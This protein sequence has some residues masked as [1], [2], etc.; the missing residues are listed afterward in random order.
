[1]SASR[2]KKN[3]LGN[4]TGMDSPKTAREIQ[5]RKEE[6]R[7]NLLYGTIAVVFLIVAVICV[8]WKSNIIPRTVT[9]VTIG[10]EKYSA[11]EV[12][13]YFH[14]AYQSFVNQNYSYLS[15]L[16]LD[17]TKDLKDQEFGD[18]T[19]Y[20]YFLDQALTN[21]EQ[22]QAMNE[23]AE[24]EGFTWT[25][26]L[27][28]QLDSAMSSLESTASMYGVSEKQYLSSV[29]GSSM[30]TKIYE[31]QLKRSLLA[32][33][34]MQEY[35]DSLTYSDDQ[36]TE[37]YNADPDS[38]DK[39]SYESVRING[40]ADTTDADGNEIEVT[41][42]MTEAAMAAAKE[43][44]DSMYASWQGGE[45]LSDLADANEDATYT[46]TE[47]SS[48][49]DSV[50]GNWLFD[51][52]RQA[53]DSAVLEDTDSSCYYVVS[54]RDRY[55]ETA[56]VVNVRHILIQ[57]EE[58]TLSTDDEGYDADVEAKNEAAKQQA[59]DILAEW[60]AGDATED[61][62]IALVEEYSADTGSV[63]DGGLIADVSP[64][65]SLVESFRDWCVDPSRQVGDTG[66]VESDY[67]YHIMYCSSFG[68]PY[69]KILV[70]SQLASDDFNEWFEGAVADYT[71]EQQDFGMKLV[72]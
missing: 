56:P 42:E 7:T 33:A 17:T 55:Q 35:E 49:T 10:D 46:D 27:Q 16:G 45:S 31:E 47:R 2:E 12:N 69:W 37:A 38:Y 59:E 40:A 64:D 25:D 11:A 48:Y 53:G 19:W 36:L 54:F 6:K 22:V 70:R 65:S 51:S 24:Q 52:S 15:M 14:T 29:F 18:G 20:D 62:F 58:T 8:I 71:A 61:S 57:P 13:Y 43:A 50:L 60:K 44:A 72:G 5:Q 28:S 26:D 66:I 63:P 67:G 39:V 9:A 32:D 21:M 30:S 23:L 68:E 41:D 3:R 1:M 34:Y 4:P